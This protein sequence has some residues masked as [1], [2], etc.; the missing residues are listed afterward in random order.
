VLTERFILNLP[1]VDVQ[2]ST[3]ADIYRV[4]APGGLFLM[5][6]GSME[7][8]RGLNALRT[9][10]GLDEILPSSADNLSSLR[11]EDEEIEAFA[12]ET[13][14]ELLAKEGFSFF[15]AVSRALHPAM[16]KPRKPEFRAR[17][18]DLARQLQ[19]MMDPE[20]GVGSNV[21][22]VLRKRG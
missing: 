8:L 4:L 1:T 5:C 11:F 19:E 7:G 12:E 18:N 15:F 16:I 22:W 20:P 14:F 9:G 13:G 10:L 17:I 6:E 3:I 21:L 2:K